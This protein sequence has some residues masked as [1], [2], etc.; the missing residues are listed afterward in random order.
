MI[1]TISIYFA[2][3]KEGREAYKKMCI[4]AEKIYKKMVTELKE[5]DKQKL[6]LLDKDAYDEYLHDLAWNKACEEN[7]S[8]VKK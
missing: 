1:P 8:T 5:E 2:R 6:H 4:K 7:E 3:T